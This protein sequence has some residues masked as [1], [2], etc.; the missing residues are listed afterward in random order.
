MPKS[1]KLILV[2][3]LLLFGLF[4]YMEA[5]RPEPVDWQPTYS[6]YD[7]IPLGTYV[8]F[9]SLSDKST[10]LEKVDQPPYLFLKDSTIHGTYFFIHQK[11]GFN[12][13]AKK[14]LFDWVSK[15]NTLFVSAYYSNLF[16]L[17]S[18]NLEWRYAKSK[19]KI[20]S[21][22]Q[23]NL[24]NPD[25]RADSMF[26]FKH[27]AK[28]GF[29]HKIDTARQ[30]VL[31]LAN[32]NKDTVASTKTGVNLLQIPLGEGRIILSTTPQAFSNFFML[33]AEN[34]HYI[35]KVLAYVDLKEPVY[36]DVYY[37]P[38]QPSYSSPLYVLF[39][40]KY[41]KWGYYF[42]LIGAVLFIVFQGKRK[43]KAIKVIPRLQNK[44]YEFTQTVAGMYLDRKDH[45]AIAHK[46][47]TQFLGFVET[48]LRTEVKRVDK[49]LIK[50]L[51]QLT[52]NSEEE[53]QLLFKE[54]Q[55]LQSQSQVSKK[56][57]L[58]LNEMLNNFKAKI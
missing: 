10:Q 54:I 4:V 9:H 2:F 12:K 19:K 17:D 23:Y 22:P 58:T 43:Q 16:D 33:T 40:N 24:V 36:Y 57:L 50:R 41:L 44:T 11:I 21:Y 34:Y 7:K 47:I 14:R 55:R 38:N 6:I 26:V 48:E 29:F 25:L 49:D 13:A 56:E 51:A 53:I 28:L 1:Y 39:K 3:L 30:T 15:G 31:G 42:L 27:N 8:F 52:H 46:K 45:T 32:F 5:S 20:I 18:L 35:E 37:D